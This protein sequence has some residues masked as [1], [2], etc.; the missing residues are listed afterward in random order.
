[1]QCSRLLGDHIRQLAF[2]VRYLVSRHNFDSFQVGR[3][4]LQTLLVYTVEVVDSLL[5]IFASVK[6]VLRHVLSEG[7][8]ASSHL[9]N[10][11][12]VALLAF[13]YALNL[14]TLRH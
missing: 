10:F 12:V 3:H 8:E 9:L 11:V 7:F 14:I 6:E 5:E 13:G 4:V 2:F 1:M